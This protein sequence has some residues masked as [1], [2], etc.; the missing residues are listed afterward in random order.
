M[1]II[2]EVLLPEP[3]NTTWHECIS[4]YRMAR[5]AAITMLKLVS[6]KEDVEITNLVEAF[7]ATCR[8]QLAADNMVYY[9]ERLVMLRRYLQYARAVHADRAPDD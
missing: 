7:K 6:T 2:E 8:L 4:A 1:R 3:Q 5:R 9:Q